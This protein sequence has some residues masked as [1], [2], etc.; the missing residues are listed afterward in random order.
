MPADSKYGIYK[1]DQFTH[2]E[3]AVEESGRPEDA[4]DL[5]KVGYAE[6]REDGREFSLHLSEIPV[7][8]EG[9]LI[10]LK[11]SDAEA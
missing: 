5:I 7:P 9:D 2:V 4:Y 6:R 10:I 3:D 11:E 8:F 1:L